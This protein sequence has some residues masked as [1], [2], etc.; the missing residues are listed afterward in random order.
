VEFREKQHE[1]I[2][3]APHR[4]MRF[5]V[6][7]FVVYVVLFLLAL[8]EPL[9]AQWA[10]GTLPNHSFQRELFVVISLANLIISL[11]MAILG[12][13]GFSVSFTDR[14][15]RYRILAICFG[16]LLF[17]IILVGIALLTDW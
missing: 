13:I 9:I 3:A 5:G 2:T 17:E 16:P 11:L 12:I 15:L 6:L 10:F 4:F 8:I 7:G 1:T 14:K